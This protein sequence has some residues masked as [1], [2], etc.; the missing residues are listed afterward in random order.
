MVDPVEH[1]LALQ[2]SRHDALSARAMAHDALRAGGEAALLDESLSFA[3][4]GV[5]D[6]WQRFAAAQSATWISYVDR[7]TGKID[8][9]EG[10]NLAWIPGAGNTLAAS[11]L[12]GADTLATLES[13]ARRQLADLGDSLGV[14]PSSLVLNPGRSGQRG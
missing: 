11:N 13:L 2:R 14:D 6:A 7:R 5:D 3:A 4:Q 9:A 10:G 1:R 12:S 8:Y